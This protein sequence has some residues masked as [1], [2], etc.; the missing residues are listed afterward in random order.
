SR[1]PA[2]SRSAMARRAPPAASLVAVAR[3]M[4]LPPPVMRTRLPSTC[5]RFPFPLHAGRGGR[6]VERL[7]R[8]RDLLV[9]QVLNEQP[10]PWA[11]GGEQAH[12][13]GLIEQ[14]LPGR[15]LGDVDHQ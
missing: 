8:G 5:I 4:P 13:G 2:S 15:A 1:A 6:R 3:P 14:P 11:S 10:A 9:W 7:L 12:E